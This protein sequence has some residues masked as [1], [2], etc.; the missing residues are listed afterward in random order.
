MNLH[1]SLDKERQGN[2][3]PASM[4]SDTEFW[5]IWSDEEI[6]HIQKAMLTQALSELR[7]H[8]KSP[9]M[10]MEA[11][12]WLMSDDDHPFCSRLCAA[13]NGY[14]IDILRCQ[15]RRLVKDI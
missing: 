10:R 1:P 6:I 14:D 9:K 13:N 7:D 15:V 2:L 11:W 5:F 3:F 4:D 12:N 8:R